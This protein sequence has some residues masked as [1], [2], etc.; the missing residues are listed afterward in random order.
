MLLNGLRLELLLSA[1]RKTYVVVDFADSDGLVCCFVEID[2][3]HVILSIWAHLFDQ[4]SFHFQH[5]MSN[6]FV[7]MG[8]SVFGAS[9]GLY[10]QSAAEQAEDICSVS[11]SIRLPSIYVFMLNWR[12]Y[13]IY[14]RSNYYANRDE[15]GG[16]II[17]LWLLSVR[18]IF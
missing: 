2:L 17:I 12:R 15:I 11:V 7:N 5:L 4:R 13:W 1:I 3:Q 6:E 18:G 9:N 16:V 8:K 10:G 14:K